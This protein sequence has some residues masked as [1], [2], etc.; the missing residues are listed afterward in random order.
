[1]IMY[2]NTDDNNLFTDTHWVPTVHV[3]NTPGLAIK[4]YIA[5][6]ANPTA[7]LATQQRSAWPSAPSMTLFSSPRPECRAEAEDLIKPDITAP[8]IQILAGYS[9]YPEPNTTPPDELFAAIAGTSMSSPHMAGYFALMKEA[10]PDW[11]AAAAKSAYM[12][13]AN[14]KVVDNDRVSPATPFSM[15]A[16]EV[17]VPGMDKPGTAF[18]P[19]LVYDAGLFEY[20][21]F[22]CGANYG[23]FTPGS[24]DFLESIGVPSEAYNLNVP[25][26]GIAN[27][28]GSQTVVRTV[29]NVS[30]TQGRYVAQVE[31]PEGYEVAV[32]PSTL[33]LDSGDSATFEVTVTNVSAP[34]DEWRF[35]SL[36][37]KT[38]RQP[39]GRSQSHRG[40]GRTLRSPGQHLRQRRG[41]L[42]QLRREL[43]L[44]GRLHGRR[45]RSGTG[46]RDYG[47]GG[48]R[49][50]PDFRPERRIQQPAHVRPERRGVLPHRHAAGCSRRPRHRP[51]HLRL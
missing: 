44:Y 51:G 46:Q 30:A 13:T 1:M 16:G 28:P 14:P 39:H 49:P 40:E 23:I 48:A 25:S 17:F 38:A 47:Y 4:A 15:G 27:V 3:D 43:R 10:H 11:S 45:S 32:N 35:G 8:G 29:T 20:A 12:T 36:T 22:S 34:A 42:G 24:C 21:A 50:G 6:D 7:R 2:E 41:W 18:Q 33:V 19:G 5:A 37:W 26:I 9:P 31:A